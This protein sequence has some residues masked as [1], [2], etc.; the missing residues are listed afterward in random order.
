MRHRYCT[1]TPICGT[2]ML[3]PDVQTQPTFQLREAKTRSL[4]ALFMIDPDGNINGSWAGYI[5]YE[6]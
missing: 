6:P 1:G 2:V 3:K 4:Y 5:A